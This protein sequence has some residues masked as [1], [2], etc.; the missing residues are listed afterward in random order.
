MAAAKKS[1]KKLTK[2]LAVPLF[3]QM[4]IV[5]NSFEAMYA[6]LEKDFKLVTDPDENL[7]LAGAAWSIECTDGA[8]VFLLVADDLRTLC[9]ESV[10]AAWFLLDHARIKVDVHNH[11]ALAYLTD[12][13]F[14][15]TQKALKL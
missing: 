6:L 3:D 2:K 12:W 7:G 13:I 4:L 15:T 10:H 11:E 14:D 5:A 8:I 9:H 1:P